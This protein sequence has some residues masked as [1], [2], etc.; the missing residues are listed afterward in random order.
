MCGF[1][2]HFRIIE[3]NLLYVCLLVF[4]IYNFRIIYLNQCVGLEHPQVSEMNEGRQETGE[5]TRTATK[6]EFSLGENDIS[7]TKE[8]SGIITSIKL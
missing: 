5:E 1:F 7:K 8:A 4:L 3:L 2:F 6:D